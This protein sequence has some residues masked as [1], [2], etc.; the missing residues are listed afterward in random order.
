MRSKISGIAITRAYLNEIL[1]SAG[2]LTPNL[3]LLSIRSKGEVEVIDI[4]ATD[5][6]SENAPTL[7]GKDEAR[8]SLAR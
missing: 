1:H 6:G 2:V 3:R 8:L 7:R 5:Y 4:C